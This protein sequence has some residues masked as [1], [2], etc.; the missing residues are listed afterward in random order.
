LCGKESE[1]DTIEQQVIDADVNLDGKVN[2][3]DATIV[4]CYAA[5][6]IL[7]NDITFVDY[8]KEFNQITYDT[9]LSDE[10]EEST[11]V[12]TVIESD[13]ED[14]TELITEAEEETE[15]ESSAS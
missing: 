12:E 9:T 5:Y 10:T 8:M 2:S 1:L 15:V 4:L 6:H 7:N 3:I 13:S 11:E 14:E